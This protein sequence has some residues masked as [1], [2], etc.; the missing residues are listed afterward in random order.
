MPRY[1][2]APVAFRLPLSTVAALAELGAR[3]EALRHGALPR[4]LALSFR[5]RRS[6]PAPRPPA[7]VPPVIRAL[8]ARD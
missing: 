6:R 7:P 1:V 4:R 3:V 8:R 2:F 5:L